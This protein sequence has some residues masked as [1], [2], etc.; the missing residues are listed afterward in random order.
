MDPDEVAAVLHAVEAALVVA[1]GLAEVVVVQDA[2][3]ADLE[4]EVDLIE[5]AHAYRTA[6]VAGQLHL[7]VL[8]R[9]LAPGKIFKPAKR[10]A[11][12]SSLLF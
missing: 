12:S 1:A 4:A 9:D 5:V 11:L 7:E 8:A 10:K 6:A 3:E 2:A